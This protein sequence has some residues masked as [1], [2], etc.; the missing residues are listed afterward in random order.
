MSIP[1]EGGEG[2]DKHGQGRGSVKR[3]GEVPVGEVRPERR[4]T[5]C[6]EGQRGPQEQQRCKPGRKALQ[7]GA[8]LA[9]PSYR[10][11]GI[12]LILHV[13]HGKANPEWD[14]EGEGGF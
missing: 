12:A 14:R 7:A 13:S 11:A 5:G 1:E 2:G 8:G 10:P 3:S 4:V 6:G 9:V